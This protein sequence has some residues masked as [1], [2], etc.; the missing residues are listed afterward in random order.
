MESFVKRVLLERDKFLLFRAKAAG[1]PP[2]I[3]IAISAAAF[4][5]V[6]TMLPLGAMG[7][8]LVL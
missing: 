4:D 2:M 6:A 1:S 8:Q 5:A 3:R 7:G